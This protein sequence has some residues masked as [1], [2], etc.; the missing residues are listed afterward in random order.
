MRPPLLKYYRRITLLPAGISLLAVLFAL[1]YDRLWG[2]GSKF[3]GQGLTDYA[4]D[5]RVILTPI[6]SSLILALLSAMIFFNR[7]PAVRNRPFLS[8]LTWFLLPAAWLSFFTRYFASTGY[9]VLI[10]VLCLM[11]PYAVCLIRA[12]YRFRRAL[13]A[14]AQP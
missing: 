2:P 14:A 7:F 3:E 11:L 6:I 5:L 13:K 12:F 10:T 9:D 4:E 1:V 8:A